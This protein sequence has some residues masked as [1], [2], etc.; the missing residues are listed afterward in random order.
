MRYLRA[1][2]TLAFASL[3][4]GG[5]LAQNV[6][7]PPSPMSPVPH[8]FERAGDPNFIPATATPQ[9]YYITQPVNTSSYRAVNPCI[10]ADVRIKTVLAPAPVATTPTSYPGVSQIT[11]P[12]VNPI[13][14]IS[15]TRFT[16]RATETLGST[17]NPNTTSSV[18]RAVSIMLVPVPGYSTAADIANQ[19]C[20]FELGYGNGT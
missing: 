4:A 14:P 13:S 16:A 5:V 17:P 10:N 20:V 11:S 12:V 9:N 18:M 3:G 2:L 1:F 8:P 15:G 7:A 6:S 19:T